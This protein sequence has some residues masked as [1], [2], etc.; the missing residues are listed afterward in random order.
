M[1]QA[2]LQILPELLCYWKSLPLRKI[3]QHLEPCFWN[4]FR[5]D[6]NEHLYGIYL[7]SLI[8]E[9]FQSVLL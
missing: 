7:F 5:D 4:L 6:I 8:G 9:N 3:V 1:R 2:Y